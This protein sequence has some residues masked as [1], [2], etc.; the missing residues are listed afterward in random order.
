MKK[1]IQLDMHLQ[2]NLPEMQL[3]E[4]R[5]KQ[6]LINILNN[7][8]KFTANGGHIKLEATKLSHVSEH[9]QEHTQDYLQISITDTGI[10]I[11]P[12]NIQKLFKPF[13]QID[14][15]LNRKYE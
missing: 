13:I 8:V 14:S 3:D 12:E 10:G 1:Q 5:I 2:P 11:S 4:R 9:T 6:V 7:A 15:A